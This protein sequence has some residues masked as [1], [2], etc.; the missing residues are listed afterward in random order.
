MRPIASMPAEEAKRLRG[1][2]F[3]LDDTLLDHGRLPEAAYSSLFRLREAGFELVCVTGRS[4]GWGDVLIRQWPIA[5]AVT[6]N[7]AFA[8]LSDENAIR[9]RDAVDA[10]ERRARSA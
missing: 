4:A 6:E 10:A 2:L 8:L 7:G 5:A 1:L 9:R 3:D